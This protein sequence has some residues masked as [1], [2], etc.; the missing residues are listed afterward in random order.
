M[1]KKIKDW[2]YGKDVLCTFD[3]IQGDGAFILPTTFKEQHWTGKFAKVI[4]Q[5]LKRN[6]KWVISTA[7]ALLAGF[8]T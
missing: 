8:S 6:I 4:G 5:S 1:F 3:S 7:L 2:Y